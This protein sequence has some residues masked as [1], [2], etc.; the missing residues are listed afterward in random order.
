MAVTRITSRWFSSFSSIKI[1]EELSA[2]QNH[3]IQ[4]ILSLQKSQKVEKKRTV[5]QGFYTKIA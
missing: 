5:R 1:C 4:Q 3:E 2:K